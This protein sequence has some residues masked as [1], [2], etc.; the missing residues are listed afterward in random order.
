MPKYNIK[1]CGYHVYYFLF[2]KLKH[3]SVISGR[4]S[5][6]KGVQVDGF[7]VQG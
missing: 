7:R 1:T 4:V 3:Y 6:E 2:T 5:R